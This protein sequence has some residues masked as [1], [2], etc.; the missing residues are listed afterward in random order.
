M[1]TKKKASTKAKT[2]TDTKKVA[3]GKTAST[4]ATAKKAPAKK[5]AEKKTGQK[6]GQ[7]KQVVLPFQGADSPTIEMKNG[8]KI[9]K[10]E[11][12]M[13]SGMLRLE[14]ERGMQYS[15]K[16]SGVTIAQ[17]LLNTKKT[18]DNLIAE[19]AT[20]NAKNVLATA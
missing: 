3:K 14:V 15:E 16:V 17:A 18:G 9:R 4:K 2:A 5:P 11:L 6:T 7:A 12:P 8:Q 10:S 1:A 13:I 20:F 19:L